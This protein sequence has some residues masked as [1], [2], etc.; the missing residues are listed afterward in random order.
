MV[1]SIEYEHEHVVMLKGQCNVYKAI[2]AMLLNIV[3]VTMRILAGRA[4]CVKEIISSKKEKVEQIMM[5][6]LNNS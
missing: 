2:Q 3:F 6:L 1:F 5:S 4:A